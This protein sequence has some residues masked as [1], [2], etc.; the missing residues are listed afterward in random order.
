[1][2]KSTFI[3]HSA[4]EPAVLVR[5]VLLAADEGTG[6]ES[7]VGS[8]LKAIPMPSDLAPGMSLALE[9]FGERHIFH[10]TDILWDEARQTCIVEVAWLASDAA[11]SLATV[12]VHAVSGPQERVAP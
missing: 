4:A 8:F 10:P 7:V 9:I 11:R 6:E 1:V 3:D 5:L 12:K 2:R